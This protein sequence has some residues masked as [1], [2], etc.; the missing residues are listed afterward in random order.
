MEKKIG[1][2]TMYSDNYGACLQAYALQ[3]KLNNLGY[4]V[5]QINYQ[6]KSNI[7]NRSKIKVILS[8]GI[9]GIIQLLFSKKYR[10][11]RKNEFNRFR[12]TFLNITKNKY[13]S[14]DLSLLNADYD[15][16]ISGSDMVFSDEF[17]DD[18]HFYYLGF[19][20]IGKAIA[21]APSFGKCDFSEDKIDICKNYLKRYNRISCREKSGCEFVEN[22]L[23]L[24]CVNVC[25]PT[26]LLKKEEWDDLA[27]EDC[28]SN[29]AL[30]Y[31]FGGE[32]GERKKVFRELEK[33]ISIEFIPQSNSQFKKAKNNLSLKKYVSLFKN[34][35]FVVTDTFHGLMF[36]LI[37]EKPFV[38][39]KRGNNEHW[40]KHS[41]RITSLLEYLK[42]SDRYIGPL[43][44]NYDNFKK[45]DYDPV[46]PLVDKFRNDSIAYLID[47]LGAIDE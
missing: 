6:K 39:L 15:Y 8:L 3:K 9:K 38:V 42:L 11:M 44:F 29:Y 27:S 25:D 20:D 35:D 40:G 13:F 33:N 41:D 2:A 10:T 1:V 21:Y 22:D 43:D 47:T 23:G 45:L 34:A 31:V 4:Q 12:S 5:E 32:F 14:D 36:S 26:F 30:S 24:K 16:F 17:F 7:Q 18:W 28:P 19:A 37:F 46:R